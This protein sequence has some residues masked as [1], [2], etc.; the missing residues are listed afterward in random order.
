MYTFRRVEINEHWELKNRWWKN[1]NLRFVRVGSVGGNLIPAVRR[2]RQCRIIDNYLFIYRTRISILKATDLIPSTFPFSAYIFWKLP[3][4]IFSIDSRVCTPKRQRTETRLDTTNT[5]GFLDDITASWNVFFTIVELCFIE[6]VYHYEFK[7][8][9]FFFYRSYVTGI[10]YLYTRWQCT[11]FRRLRFHGLTNA[12]SCW[13]G[14]H[15]RV[16]PSELVCSRLVRKCSAQVWTVLRDFGDCFASRPS[17]PWLGVIGPKGV[18]DFRS[19][20]GSGPRF[21]EAK[22]KI[23]FYFAI[24]FLF[25][26]FP[27]TKPSTCSSCLS[28][29]GRLNP[30]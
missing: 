16:C 17:A 27:A 7:K 28:S 30:L 9:N 18:G 25:H 2:F 26:H 8:K 4:V 20:L 24:L 15:V 14:A 10:S 11:R 19:P 12:R 13:V 29:G 6:Y 21:Y 3:T 23:I 22:E 1:I 5:Y